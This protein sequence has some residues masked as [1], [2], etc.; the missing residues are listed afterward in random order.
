MPRRP[1]IAY[2]LSHWP[3]GQSTG[4]RLRLRRIGDTLR[5]IGEVSLLS[6]TSD[7]IDADELREAREDFAEVTIVPAQRTPLRGVA[8]RLRHELDPGFLNTHRSSIDSAERAALVRRMSS[9]DLFWIH[10][11]RSANVFGVA[12][13][14]RSVLDVDDLHSQLYASMADAASA[15]L[16]RLRCRRMAWLWR[17]R[18]RRFPKRFDTIAVC[19]ESD[20]DALGFPEIT[21]VVP[22]GFDVPATEPQYRPS[23]QR[24]GFIG[25]LDY[26]PNRDGLEWFLGDVWPAVKQLVPAARLRLV[27]HG[28]SPEL[29]ASTKDV[30]LLGYL[31]DPDGEMATWSASIVP[32]R[33][34]AGTRVKIADAFSRKCPVVSTSLGAFG[35]RVSHAQEILLADTADDFAASCATLLA[36]PEIGA[37]IS[38]TAWRRFK[39]EMSWEAVAGAV[40]MC[41]LR[42]LALGSVATRSARSSD[43]S[44]DAHTAWR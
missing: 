20:R 29:A 23:G 13:W 33:F 19:S 25:L 16:Q 26:A 7:T 12:R 38:E 18:E 17:A 44:D 22:N 5:R 8:D 40:Q 2:V 9:F 34:G 32:L 21:R 14:P 10:T 41:A 42:T 30:D 28:A 36:H 43:R 3:Y 11:I 1:R 6:C 37:R 35:Y 27:G 31:P 39:A 24:I 15:P 4:Q